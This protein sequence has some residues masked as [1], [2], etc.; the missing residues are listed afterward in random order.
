MDNDV[1]YIINEAGEKEYVIIPMS[2]YEEFIRMKTDDT[3]PPE[4]E[5]PV[6]DIPY[7]KEELEQV[8]PNPFL[9]PESTNQE[10]LQE[11][12]RISKDLEVRFT[13]CY[14]RIKQ[15]PDPEQSGIE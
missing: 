10:I 3:S 12:Q 15:F 4:K 11:L 2:M 14:V 9:T 13:G 8:I 6:A 1:K 5:K 7:T